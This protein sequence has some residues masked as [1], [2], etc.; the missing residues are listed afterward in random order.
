MPISPTLGAGSKEKPPPG[1]SSQA[2]PATRTRTPGSGPLSP[3]PR[4]GAPGRLPG[5]ARVPRRAPRAG[6][7]APSR[8]LEQHFALTLAPAPGKLRGSAGARAGGGR[9]G[10]PG[11]GTGAP[12]PTAQK[13]GGR[14]AERKKGCRAPRRR[15]RGHPN[16]S[17]CRASCAGSPGCRRRPAHGPPEPGAPRSPAQAGARPPRHRLREPRA[18]RDYIS[19]GARAWISLGLGKVVPRPDANSA[20][21]GWS[22]P[23]RQG[24]VPEPVARPAPSPRPA[25]PARAH[26]RPEQNKS[27]GAEGRKLAGPRGLGRSSRDRRG[28]ALRVGHPWSSSSPPPSQ[29]RG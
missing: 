3:P 17:G 6:S 22:Q 1:T 7:E 24:A 28:G 21:P 10:L 9:P 12:F 20:V 11:G 8:Q 23:G 18:G 19:S 2:E 29:T 4:P 25:P 26:C 15:A 16:S 5:G 27:G 14:L 13:D